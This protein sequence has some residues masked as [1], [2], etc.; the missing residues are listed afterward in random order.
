[1]FLYISYLEGFL[2]GRVGDW[3]ARNRE[4]LLIEEL[5][6]AHAEENFVQEVGEAGELPA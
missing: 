1:M 2:N 3:K 5:S 6:I 4:E